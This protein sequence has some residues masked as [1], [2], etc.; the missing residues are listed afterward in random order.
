MFFYLKIISIK[1]KKYDIYS[2]RKYNI[3]LVISCFT[4]FSANFRDYGKT[5]D[6]IINIIILI[7]WILSILYII[8][9][10]IKNLKSK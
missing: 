7:V 9:L 6:D 3:A 5:V 1:K 4:M 8:W 2:L 10:H